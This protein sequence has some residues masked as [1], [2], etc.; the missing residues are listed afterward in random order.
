MLSANG[1]RV[2]GVVETRRIHQALEKGMD[3]GI[4]PTVENSIERVLQHTDGLGADGCGV[5]AATESHQVISE[6]MQ[7]CR[8]NGRILLVNPRRRREHLPD[9]LLCFGY[10]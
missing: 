6:A 10:D 3:V 4:D 1:C 2:I 8:K 9:K 7:C 5:T